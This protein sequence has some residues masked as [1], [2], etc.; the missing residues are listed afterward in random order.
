MRAP[1]LYV[2]AQA[3]PWDDAPASPAPKPPRPMS[4]SDLQEGMRAYNAGESQGSSVRTGILILIAFIA[5][6]ALVLHLWQRRK[7]GAPPDSLGRVGWDLGRLVP[8]PWGTRLLLWWVARSAD[9]S[10]CVVR[11]V[12]VR[13]G[14][15]GRAG[16]SAG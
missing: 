6:L 5:V 3:N 9:R 4:F 13:C 16:E 2:L 12:A 7:T 11:V 15:G 10:G 8:F 1:F 14:R